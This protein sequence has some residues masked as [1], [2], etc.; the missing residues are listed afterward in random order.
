LVFVI[1]PT[2]HEKKDMQ[3]IPVVR[4][5]PDVFSTNYFGLLPQREVKFGIKRMLGTNLISK[6][7]YK[8]ALLELKELKEQL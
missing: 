6:A 8:M 2:R 4:E 3:V 5:Y 1:A 7:P